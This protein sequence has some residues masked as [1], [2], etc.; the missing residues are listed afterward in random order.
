M[1]NIFAKIWEKNCTKN[2]GENSE[3]NCAK[4][5]GICAKIMEKLWKNWGKFVQK[6]EGKIVEKIG[7]K[8][9]I[10]GKIVGK[11]CK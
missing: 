1:K 9:V 10:G 8:F 2:Y 3:K 11:I 6:I 4:N 7:E 5:W